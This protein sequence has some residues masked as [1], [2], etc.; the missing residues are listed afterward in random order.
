MDEPKMSDKPFDRL[1]SLAEVM[2]NALERAVEVEKTLDPERFTEVRSIVFLEDAYGAG[3]EVHGYQDGVEAM[4]TLFM[5]MKAVF[6]ASGKD[7]DFI[8]IPDS[9]QGLS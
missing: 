7:L 3:I 5:H 4:A 1:T 9:P 6:R 8:G 2:T